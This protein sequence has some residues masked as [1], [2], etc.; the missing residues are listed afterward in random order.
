LCLAA[1]PLTFAAEAESI[2]GAPP[3]G[4]RWGMSKPG[5]WN[6]TIILDLDGAGSRSKSYRDWLL[7]Q[8]FATGGTQREPVGY[9]FVKAVDNLIAV[10]EQFITRVV[11]RSPASATSSMPCSR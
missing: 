3:D 1:L 11:G 4:T 8:G 2:S 9:D 7:S 5:N 10:R 6:G